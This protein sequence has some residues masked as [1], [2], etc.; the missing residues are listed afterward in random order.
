MEKKY[1]QCEKAVDQYHR[2]R[3]AILARAGRTSTRRNHG[4]T[5]AHPSLMAFLFLNAIDRFLDC[6]FAI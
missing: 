1:E 5:I 2:P 3:C 6:F 4:N